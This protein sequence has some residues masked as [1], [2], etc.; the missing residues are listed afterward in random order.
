MKDNESQPSKGGA[1]WIFVSTDTG[2]ARRPADIILAVVGALLIL[3][4][5]FGVQQFQWMDDFSSEVVALLPSWLETFLALLYAIGFVFALVIVVMAI[6]QWSTMASLVRDLAIALGL[7]AV[8][9]LGLS[10]LVADAFPIVLPE[11]YSGGNADLYV[12]VDV[13]DNDRVDYVSVSTQ[14]LVVIDEVTC[15]DGEVS[16]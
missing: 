7:T 12:L 10:Y 4:T 11:F 13:C 15:P 9:I 2:R 1:S 8:L 3:S 16:Q 14:R 5:A 6:I